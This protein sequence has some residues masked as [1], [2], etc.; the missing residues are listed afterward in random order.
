MASGYDALYSNVAGSYGTAVGYEAMYFASD[1]TTAFNSNNTAVGYQALQGSTTPSHNTGTTNTAVGASA[2]QAD[3]SGFSNLASGASALYKNTT[4]GQNTASGSAALYSNTVGANNVASG[5]EALYSN[6]SGSGSTAVG[7][8]AMLY[9][10]SSATPFFT[11]N[12]AVGY[13]ALE[14]STT[15]ANNTGV[16]N[17]AIGYGVLAAATSG[18]NNTA[19][20]YNALSLDTSGANNTAIGNQVA[21][22]TLTTG[23]S[24][25]LI[26][27][28]TVGVAGGADTPLSSTSNFLNIGNTLEG[29]MA[30]ASAIGK[31]TLYLNSV[32]SSVNYV[33]LSG[34]ATG[35]GPTIASAGTDTNVNLTLS[36]QG[37]GN[38]IIS[39][40]NVGIGTASPNGLLQVY[41]T[42]IQ[43][44][45]AQLT[46]SATTGFMNIAQTNGT[47]AGTP[48]GLVTGSVPI[49]VDTSGNLYAW[50]G[51]AWV[52]AG[53]SAMIYPASGI[54]VSTGSAWGT[55]LQ[56]G[57]S[58]GVV[59]LLNGNNTYSGTA[60]FTGATTYN[61]ASSV[62]SGASATLN[63]VEVT[64]ATTTITGVT[65]IA[66]ANGFNK[67]NID[68]PTYNDSSG[69]E[70][71]TNGATLGITGVPTGSATGPVTITNASAIFVP[72]SVVAHVTNAYGLN[73]AATTGA[74]NN[75]A[76]AFTG[77]NVGIGT[78][79]PA[80]KLD[81][82]TSA[83]VGAIDLG[84]VNGISYPSTDSTAGG[85]I[86]IGNGALVEEPS[87]TSTAFHNTAVGYQTLNSAS[88]TT[89]ATLNVAVGYQTLYSNT[90]GNANTAE[91]ASALYSNLSGT[92][93]TAI[94]E[95]ALYT[96]SGG[97]GN[98]AVGAASL[99]SNGSGG[100]NTAIGENALHNNSTSSN[101]TALGAAA[102]DTVTGSNN[103]GLG[104]SVGSVTLTTGSSNIL[105]GTSSA[106][107]TPASGTSNFLNIGN[108]IFATGMTGTVASP[109]GSVG[110]GT[111]APSQLL[112]V[113]GNIDITGSGF[114][115]LTEIAN[116]GT[117]GTTANMLA[118]LT[119]AG[120][121]IIAATTDTDG[122]IGVV[123]GNA[124]KTGNAQVA[125]DG[126]ASCVFDG[127]T[128]A[129][130]FV[131]ISSS[132]AGEC[133][134]AGSTRSASS[135]TIG[136]VLTTNAS[137]GTYTVELGLNASAASSGEVSGSGT[138]NYVARWTPNGTTLGI[139][140]LYDTGS[141][142]SVGTTTTASM[143]G[144]Y[145]GI[146]R[147][148]DLCID[149]S[150][151]ERSD[152]SG[153]RRDWD[154]SA[155]GEAGCLYLGCFGRLISAA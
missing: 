101:N 143:L 90:S 56:T 57:T 9:A 12:T 124:G 120:A 81:V 65:T 155:C 103:L 36:P 148:H 94:G 16:Q 105:I 21:S 25:I 132:T 55:S 112:T 5:T 100:T 11:Y 51:A 116:D 74:T 42:E 110:I 69:A 30:N 28:G 83:G 8:Y 129:G 18:G 10:N 38:T 131:A 75:Y 23:S 91:G 60:L 52:K 126:Q 93:N 145:G 39:S 53:A 40:G 33:Q 7:Y 67:I 122:M 71:I 31:E 73:V 70:S 147:R 127:A 119:T 77:G 44:T 32:A 22:T 136:R 135:Q 68:Q 118:K 139:G 133:H 79:G 50:S 150:P 95:N 108:V 78:T 115:F 84:G 88:M 138:T 17:T 140:A 19:L 76:A 62:A 114:G 34:G 59:P 24:N 35:T 47:P 92:I 142:V 2:L 72:T 4:G 87:L 82:Y 121:A 64:A 45:G 54:A 96:N 98:V 6:V 107:D 113:G 97:A 106:V 3:T 41:G 13:N 49:T 144:V 141:L 149:R 146:E 111:T 99:Y 80:A 29:N 123:T 152:H 151:D 128:T 14:G 63:D 15:A 1:S 26:G 20:G 27:V 48:A 153:Q 37:T 58:G 117:T 104:Y 154:D 102:L 43:G 137:G 125:V 134:D 61:V 46:T 130:D 85:S 109:A 89:A 66:T 86:A